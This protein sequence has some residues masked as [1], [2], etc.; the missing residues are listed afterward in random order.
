MTS[1]TIERMS[2]NYVAR[3]IVRERIVDGRLN[4]YVRAVIIGNGRK[5]IKTNSFYR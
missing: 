3:Y 4:V 1:R 2:R 5:V